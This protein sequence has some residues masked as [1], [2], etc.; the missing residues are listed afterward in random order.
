MEKLLNLKL[1]EVYYEVVVFRFI[2]GE[3]NVVW[4]LGWHGDVDISNTCILFIL[5]TFA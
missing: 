1:S 4:W 2:M 3:N 5:Y